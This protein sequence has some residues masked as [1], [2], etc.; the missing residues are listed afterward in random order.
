MRVL[1]AED[2]VAMAQVMRFNLQRAGFTVQLAADG[3]L[4]LEYAKGTDFDLIITDFQMPGMNGEELC[5]ALR[6]LSA[7]SDTPVLMCTAKGLE[8]DPLHLHQELGVTG[9]VSKPFSPR[10][11]VE[12]AKA[13][14]QDRLTVSV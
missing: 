8:L 3:R 13:L 11:I 12:T 5:R 10:K 7:Y 6:Q 14:V 2:N 9:L 4:A 1:I